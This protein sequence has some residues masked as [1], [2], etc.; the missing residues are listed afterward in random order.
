MANTSPLPLTEAYGSS[1]ST[2]REIRKHGNYGTYTPGIRDRHFNRLHSIA[3]GWT[4][5]AKRM[6]INNAK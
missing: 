3:V 5:C 2:E 6:D 4:N 1:P